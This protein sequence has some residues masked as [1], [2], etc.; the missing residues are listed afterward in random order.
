MQSP[1]R[2]Q[3]FRLAAI[4][5]T[6]PGE[7]KVPL[8]MNRSSVKGRVGFEFKSQSVSGRMKEGS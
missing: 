1:A 3:Y 4:R 7:A 8:R 6:G 2:R 5:A